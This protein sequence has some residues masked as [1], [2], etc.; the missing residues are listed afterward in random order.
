MSLQARLRHTLGERW[1][2][3]PPRGVDEP[4][5]VGRVATAD[6]QIPSVTV[7]Q[8]HCVLFVHDGLWVV[9]DV[10]G[11]TGTYVNG[12]KIDGPTLLNVGDVITL[13]PEASAP[14]MD[15]DPAAAAEGRK[16]Q[17]ATAMA[18]RVPPSS[19]GVVPETPAP[20]GP[21]YP[22]AVT[23]PI[24]PPGYTPPPPQYGTGS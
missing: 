8:K 18:A 20:V 4:L 10:P 15:V 16:G 21:E 14:S 22:P 13:G 1:I 3:L 17:P 7:A 12:A 19:R 11:S 23:P 9:Q 24:Y 2:E 5:V 6:V